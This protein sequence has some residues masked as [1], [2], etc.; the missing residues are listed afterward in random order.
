MIFS[1]FVLSITALST[2][3]VGMMA[4]EFEVFSTDGRQLSLSEL[5]K[6]GSVMLVF[7]RGFG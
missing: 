1:S 4:P 3:S 2:I 7:L 6:D 5:R